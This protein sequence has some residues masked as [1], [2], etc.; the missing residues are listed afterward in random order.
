MTDKIITMAELEED[1]KNDLD[2][3]NEPFVRDKGK[4]ICKEDYPDK[5]ELKSSVKVLDTHDNFEFLIDHFGIKL[6][7]NIMRRMREV[8]IPHLPTFQDD[9]ENSALSIIINLAVLNY[10][11]ISLID[12]HMDFI[13][14][15]YA[16]HPIIDCLK[17]KPWDGEKRLDSFI[18]TLKTENDSFSHQL[19]R[20]WMIAA[21]AAPF[22]EEGIALQG[23]L[24]LQG[25][26]YIGKTQWVKSLDPIN[27]KAVFAGSLLD[28]TNKDC[29]IAISRHWIVELGELDGT[30]NKSDIARIK[31]FLTNDCDEIRFPYARKITRVARRST[32]IA[33]VNESKYL[34]DTTGNRRWWTVPVISIDLNHNL[35]MQQIWAEVH[36]LWKGGESIKLTQSEFET[37]NIINAEYEKID[38]LEEKFLMVFDFSEGWQEQKTHQRTATQVLNHLGVKEPTLGECCRMSSI[39]Y[40]LTGKK[41]TK[42]RMGRFFTVPRFRPGSEMGID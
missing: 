36:E 20:R 11:P 41:S 27:C 4:K 32:F 10:M 22:S 8:T 15:K 33:T 39:I 14:Q 35:D 31:G 34:V 7:W 42:S 13:A 18:K 19:V 9:R 6:R 23:A 37:L 40:K 12:S 30:F 38:P 25:K 1:L 21:I 28:P 29:L 16:Y 5:I 24:V 2:W 26:Q 17:N 3:K